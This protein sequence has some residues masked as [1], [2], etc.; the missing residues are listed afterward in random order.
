MTP[1]VLVILAFAAYRA[2]RALSLDTITI[3]IRD[4]VERWSWEKDE[5]G[6]YLYQRPVRAKLAELLACGFCSSFWLAG[7][8]Y[9]VWI[10]TTDVDDIPVLEHVITWWAIAGVAAFLIAL[11][12][13]LLREA[14]PD[15]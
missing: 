10:V 5:A 3:P 12:S 8:T 7:I 11:D 15:A 2:A 6:A 1:L 13:F 9:L 4:A 14:P